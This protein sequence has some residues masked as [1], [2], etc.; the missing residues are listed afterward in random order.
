MGL[1]RW[2]YSFWDYIHFGRKKLCLIMIKG[3]VG[4]NYKLVSLYLQVGLSEGKLSIMYMEKSIVK[5][6]IW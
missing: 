4:E 1:S 2:I 5:K 6:T 3:K